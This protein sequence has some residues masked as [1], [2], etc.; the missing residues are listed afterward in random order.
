METATSS[1]PDRL[2]PSVEKFDPLKHSLVILKPD[3]MKSADWAE[4]LAVF[5][6]N[7]QRPRLAKLI[8]MIDAE[9][10]A[11]YGAH[12]GKHFFPPLAEF[13]KSGPS[14]VILMVGD[15]ETCRHVCMSV[16]ERRVYK[17]PANLVHASDSPEAVLFET[18]IW[19]PGVLP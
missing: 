4:I 9:I 14:L 6:I 3:A 12:I 17:N 2:L 15:W 13:M 10:N 16:R 19:F 8:T 11:H 18:R 5:A 1:S 7:Q